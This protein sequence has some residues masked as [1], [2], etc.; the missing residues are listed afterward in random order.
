M[1]PPTPALDDHA[2][3]AWLDRIRN[4]LHLSLGGT[5]V[6]LDG[7]HPACAWPLL[8]AVSEGATD[9]RVCFTGSEL[10][11]AP[12][13]A[14]VVL[15]NAA[16]DAELLNRVRPVIAERR[17]Q[18]FVWLRPGD[19]RELS[20]RARDFL[21]WMQQSVDVPGF[22]PAYAVVALRDRLE[23][24]AST[25]WEGPRL[26]ELVSEVTVLHSDVDEAEA[27]AAMRR[28]PV[29]VHRAGSVDEIARIEAMHRVAGEQHGIIWEEPAVLP[30]GV[31]R[32]I[33]RPLDWEVASAWLSVAGVKE[34]RIEAARLLLDP[35]EVARRAGRDPPPLGASSEL[36]PSSAGTDALGVGPR[37]MHI[38]AHS[39]AVTLTAGLDV[40]GEL[41]VRH[42]GTPLGYFGSA[43]AIEEDPSLLPVTI[44]IL[45]FTGESQVWRVTAYHQGSQR[46][47]VWQRDA[48][49]CHARWGETE[50]SMDIEVVATSTDGE[51]RARHILIEVI[52]SH[53]DP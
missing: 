37:S 41:E 25:T 40:H 29:V 39:R 10:V 19:R 36:Q 32:I 22:A 51:Q 4:I 18:L 50:G 26:R 31:A 24:H 16:R 33:A 15:L 38:H 44:E 35:M 43:I 42:R 8:E 46:A 30:E 1:V 11:Q 53:R 13:G 12:E 34:P 9:V 45:D 6:G 47:E 27:I 3:P 2:D 52:S 5:V 21:D 28:G 49:R 48:D 20:R 17:L 23:Q 7:A 14:R